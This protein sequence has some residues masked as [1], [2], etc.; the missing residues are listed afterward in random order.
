MQ[1]GSKDVSIFAAHQTKILQ[2]LPGSYLRNVR[3]E[4]DVRDKQILD[5]TDA[6]EVEASLYA[7]SLK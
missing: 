5:W 7:E 6:K 4:L 2:S 1:K 3:F